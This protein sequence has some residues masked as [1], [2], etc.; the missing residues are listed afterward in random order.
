MEQFFGSASALAEFE[1]MENI[2]EKIKLMWGLPVSQV[3]GFLQLS[4]SKVQVPLLSFLTNWLSFQWV[5]GAGSSL[6]SSAVGPRSIGARGPTVPSFQG[7]HLSPGQRPVGHTW[8]SRGLTIWDPTVQGPNRPRHNCPRTVPLIVSTMVEP[9][10][11]HLM[12]F[13]IVIFRNCWRV[14]AA[15]VVEVRVRGRV[16][17][18]EMLATSISRSVLPFF[19]LFWPRLLLLFWPFLLLAFCTVRQL[20]SARLGG[21]WMQWRDSTKLWQLLLS[22]M[23]GDVILAWPSPTGCLP[24]LF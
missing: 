16:G 15:A 11:V 3:Y 17:G 13:I 8:L 19:G 6:G 23:G 22:R 5:S 4:F 12:N 10:W 20:W 2:Q 24:P 21:T 7:R 1:K 18:G 9:K 14:Q